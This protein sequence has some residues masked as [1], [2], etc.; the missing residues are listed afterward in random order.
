MDKIIRINVVR[1]V[2]QRADYAPRPS[3]YAHCG[4]ADYYLTLGLWGVA[5]PYVKALKLFDD[6]LQV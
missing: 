3:Y 2:K 6:I 4:I 1:S 5:H